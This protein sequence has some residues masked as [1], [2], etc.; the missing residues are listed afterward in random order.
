VFACEQMTDEEIVAKQQLVK[1]AW[2]AG[3]NFASWVFNETTCAFE[4]PIPMPTDK[5]FH[6][7]DEATLSWVHFV[8]PTEGTN[9]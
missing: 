1:D 2:A 7:W 5:N 4:A 8:K 9:V 6:R 3:N